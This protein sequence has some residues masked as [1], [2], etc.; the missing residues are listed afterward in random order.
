MLDI[1]VDKDP[2]STLILTEQGQWVVQWIVL[3]FSTLATVVQFFYP[4]VIGQSGWGCLD[5]DSSEKHAI[6]PV[7]SI[8]TTKMNAT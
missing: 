1:D 7:S 5:V 4:A 8:F 2:S 6:G 3:M